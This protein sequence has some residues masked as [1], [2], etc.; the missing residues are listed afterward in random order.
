MFEVGAE[1]EEGEPPRAAS[2]ERLLAPP[3]TPYGRL[4]ARSK[5]V[6][7]TTHPPSDERRGEDEFLHRLP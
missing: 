3:I 2:C 4:P 7:P 6:T 1:I 5:S